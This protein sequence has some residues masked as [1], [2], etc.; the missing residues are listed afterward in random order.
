[1]VSSEGGAY[2]V[3]NITRGKKYKLRFINTSVDNHFMVSLD[4]HNMIVIAADLT[5]IEP[6][7]ADW[8]FVAIGQRYDVIIEANK[9]IGNYWFRAEV[10]DQPNP[11]CG[12]NYNN[13]NIKSIFRYNR[14]PETDPTST[15]TPYTQ[16]C[17]DEI[18]VPYWDT[19]V[20]SD[21]LTEG[22][23][24]DAAIQIGVN[25][26]NNTI[27]KWGLDTTPLYIQWSKPTLEYVWEGNNSFPQSAN[28]LSVPNKDEVCSLIRSSTCIITDYS[29]VDL[30]DHTGGAGHTHQHQHPSSHPSP[31]PRLLRPRFRNRELLRHGRQH[32]EL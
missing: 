21:G 20:P 30:L 8:V 27:V 9:A 7:S 19:A 31:R 17:S 6:Y 1:M 4:N 25:A 13:G 18:V 16:R 10:Q 23:Q 32:A 3:T 15:A 12:Q 22:G 24:L 2:A 29:I 11:N 26:N 28:V 5:P 14:A